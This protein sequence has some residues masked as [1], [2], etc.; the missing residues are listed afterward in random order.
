MGTLRFFGVTAYGRCFV[1]ATTLRLV[2]DLVFLDFKK[3]DAVVEGL[4]EDDV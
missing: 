1:A 3:V 4:D 2:Y